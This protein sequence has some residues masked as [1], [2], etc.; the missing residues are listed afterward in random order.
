M[1]F[2]FVAPEAVVAAA[3]DLS[4]IGS[5]ISAANSA[6]AASATGVLAAGA[7]QVSAAIATV[8]GSHAQTYQALSAQATAFHDQFVQTLTTGVGSYAAAEAANASP[9]E[10]L[11]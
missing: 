2:V 6:A 4:G 7:D 1:S 10:Q 11:L 5:A 3:G 9:L 8:F